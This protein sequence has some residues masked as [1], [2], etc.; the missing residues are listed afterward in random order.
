MLRYWS[1]R[2][3]FTLRTLVLLAADFSSSTNSRPPVPSFVCCV[4]V[5]CP[6]AGFLSFPAPF[7]CV[8]L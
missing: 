8:F 5:A 7:P 4:G 1:S 6:C 3:Y 2:Q